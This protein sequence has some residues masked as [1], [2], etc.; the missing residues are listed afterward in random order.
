[1]NRIGGEAEWSEERGLLGG[2][3]PVSAKES[4]VRLRFDPFEGLCVGAKNAVT[5]VLKT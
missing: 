1:M 5:P 2:R 3:E 4:L